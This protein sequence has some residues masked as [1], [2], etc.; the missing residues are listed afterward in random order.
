MK[1]TLG[2]HISVTIFGGSHE[3]HIGVTIE[4]MDFRP[5]EVDM[6]VLQAFLK[7]RAPGN[8]PYATSRR[9]DDVPL[10]T[11]K[12]PPTY[13][14]KNMDRRS[15]DYKKHVDIPRPGHADLSAWVKYRGEVNMAG[16]GPFSGRMTAPLCIAG[17]IALQLLEKKGITIGAK[18]VAA[19]G[20]TGEEI[21]RAI[22][23]ARD[24]GDSVGGLVSARIDGCPPG[25]GGPMYDGL[26]SLIS[27]IVF[28]IPGVKGLSFGA[29]FSA[30]DMKGSACN[31]PFTMEEGRIVTRTNH[32]GGILGGISTGM[33]ITLDVAFKPTPSIAKEQDSVDLR[34]GE[35]TKVIVQGRHDP[36]IA[37]RAVPAVEAALALGLVDAIMGE[38]GR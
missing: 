25:I 35:N 20:S 18:L 26:E 29:G 34:T 22:S 2:K 38:K 32:A 1:S 7:R 13:V 17:G 36:C 4:G 19:G 28:G 9:E 5:S 6:D 31:D 14:I 3:D 23:R 27:P 16:G 21:Y 11:G 12:D 10:L 30:T 8:S 15:S 24:E 37:V 33:P